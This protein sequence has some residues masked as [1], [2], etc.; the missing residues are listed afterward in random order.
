MHKEMVNRKKIEKLNHKLQHSPTRSQWKDQSKPWRR[1]R[2][3][4]NFVK[5]SQSKGCDT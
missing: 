3:S 5:P 1:N 4:N 2:P